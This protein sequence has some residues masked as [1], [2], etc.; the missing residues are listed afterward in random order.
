MAEKK[1]A[2]KKPMYRGR[3]IVLDA[4]SIMGLSKNDVARMHQIAAWFDEW[5]NRLGLHPD[6]RIVIRYVGDPVDETAGAPQK[7]LMLCDNAIADYGQWRLDVSSRCLSAKR[8]A[9]RESDVIHEVLHMLIYPLYT[10]LSYYIV[11]ESSRD[12]LSR[13]EE[14]LV[15]ALEIAIV[16]LAYGRDCS[17]PPENS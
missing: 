14:S 10:R 13:A 16:R 7:Y 12:L 17:M 8:D 15:T 3:P 1:K 6:T 4:A 2:K 9:W 11:D 5:A